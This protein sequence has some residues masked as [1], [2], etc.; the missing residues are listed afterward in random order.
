MRLILAAVFL[1]AMVSLA[2]AGRNDWC[3]RDCVHK[4]ET[5][6]QRYTLAQCIQVRMCYSYPAAPCYNYLAPSEYVPKAHRPVI[7]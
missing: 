5:T 1:T 4:C 6:L 3:T 2:H 7:R